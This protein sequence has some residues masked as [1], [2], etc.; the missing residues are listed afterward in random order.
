MPPV[1]QL[2]I[3]ILKWL[4]RSLAARALYHTLVRWWLEP[5]V[6]RRRARLAKRPKVGAMGSGR[7]ETGAPPGTASARAMAAQQFPELPEVLQ[8]RIA[9]RALA[10]QQDGWGPRGYAHLY[11]PYGT[12][13]S[14]TN[15]PWD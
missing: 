2:I 12:C 8:W 13:T 1:E 10:T 6:Q 9:A 5:L 15:N 14:P 3:E 7:I 4:L 11:Q